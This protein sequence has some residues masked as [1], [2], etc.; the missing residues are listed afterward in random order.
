MWW[1]IVASNDGILGEH[2]ESLFIDRLKK[3]S[4]NQMSVCRRSIAYDNIYCENT[5]PWQKK[6]T[7]FQ[8][9][10]HDYMLITQ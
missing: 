10:T 1:Q 8:H 4:Q 9:G 3:A 2:L 6:L 5:N 7:V